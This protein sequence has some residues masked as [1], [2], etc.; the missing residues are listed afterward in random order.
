ML[1]L[2]IQAVANKLGIDNSSKFQK[3]CG[4]SS[5]SV[6]STLYFE[7][8]Q[9]IG[10]AT[11]NMLCEKLQ[12]SPGDLFVY[13]PDAKPAAKKAATKPA[14][15][16]AI[17]VPA[18]VPAKKATAKASAKVTAKPSAKKAKLPAKRKGK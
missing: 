4:I 2:N 9:S 14:K 13:T 5:P 10:L 12:C 6:A 7:R 18:K 11:I 16:T 15:P 3:H 17:K 1:K 8:G